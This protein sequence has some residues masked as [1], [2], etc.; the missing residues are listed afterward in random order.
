MNKQ[1]LRKAGGM[2][3]KACI[4]YHEAAAEN[5]QCEPNELTSTLNVDTGEYYYK[6]TVTAEPIDDE[7]RQYQTIK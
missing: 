6:I 4:V 1:E 2:L 7:D 5:Q 3:A